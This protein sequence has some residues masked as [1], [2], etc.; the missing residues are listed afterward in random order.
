MR[1][2]VIATFLILGTHGLVVGQAVMSSP[3]VRANEEGVQITARFSN[4]SKES[5]YRIG[6]G[7]TGAQLEN[8]KI[9]LLKG[10]TPLSNNL[11][12][13]KQGYT[14]SWFEV[15]EILVRGVVFTP[16]GD[17]APS[18]A[19]LIRVTLPKE[20]ADRQKRLFLIL[21]KSYGPDVWYIQEGAE[22][23]ESVW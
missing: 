15:D 16:D 6:V 11:V 13:F 1:K 9:E 21:S 17:P 14:Q 8:A 10:E 20:E 12:N 19:V 3:T 23:N 22:L 18:E 5:S 2:Y 7:T 4:F